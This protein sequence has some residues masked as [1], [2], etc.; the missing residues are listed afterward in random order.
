MCAGQARAA[1]ARAFAWG[2]GLSPAWTNCSV[3]ACLTFDLVPEFF[4]N[5]LSLSFSLHL[6]FSRRLSLSTSSRACVLSG[7][8]PPCPPL[9]SAGLAHSERALPANFLSPRPSPAVRLC[10]LR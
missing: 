7:A 1:I 5:S 2:R 6:T 9:R 3:E 10:G 4:S 8:R